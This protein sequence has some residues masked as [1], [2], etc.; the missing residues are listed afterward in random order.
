M[1]QKT[2]T[3]RCADGLEAVV[4]TKYTFKDEVDFDISVEDSYIGGSY[5]GFLGR[6]KRAWHAFKA[7]PVCYT[8]IY[9]EDAGKMKKFIVDCLALL[10]EDANNEV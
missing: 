10:E 4:F 5:K 9:C 8:G 6:L 1:D 7:K 2:V 3:L